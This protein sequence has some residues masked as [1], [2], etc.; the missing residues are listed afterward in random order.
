[1]TLI[2]AKAIIAVILI[3]AFVQFGVLYGSE[4]PPEINRIIYEMEAV[5]EKITD[6]VAVVERV[7]RE[8]G[9]GRETIAEIRL[10]YKKPDKLKLEV[11]DGRE[12]LINGGRM[13]IYSP[14]L[15][16]VETYNLKDDEQR[17]ATLY[18]MS[19]GL[20]SP[21]KSLLRGTNRS[22][23]T[24][25][26]GTI[27]VKVAPDQ[28]DARIKEILAWV[29]PRT[30]LIKR[31]VVTRAGLPPV[32]LRI[33]EWRVNTGLLDSLFDF[34]LPKGADLF[35]PLNGPGEVLH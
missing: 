9:S 13:W 12:V 16:I 8:P 33:K 26:D 3:F 17:N 27:L 22:A 29:D 28:K 11:K 30:W 2:L 6:L 35:K 18:E 23:S 32:R 21:I 25:E 15:E 24:L 14:D 7:S 4:P 19:W 1:M 20:T 31:M 34:K 5:R 10:I